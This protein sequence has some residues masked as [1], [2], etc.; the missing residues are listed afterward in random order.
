MHTLPAP[1]RQRPRLP[2]RRRYYLRRFI[3]ALLAIVVVTVALGSISL[4]GALRTPGNQS[5]QAKWADW[6]RAHHAGLIASAV[7]QYYY[8]HNAP[9]KGGRPAELNP[10]L[11]PAASSG[12]QP[13]TP[14][15]GLPRPVPIPLVVN[16]GLPGEGQWTP[17]GAVVRDVPA[18]YV[19]QFRADTV[20]TSQITSAVW[21]DPTLLRVALVPGAQ[22]PGGT[23]PQPPDVTDAGLST[24]VAA[25]NGGFRMADA[26]GGFYL[27]GRQAV[28]LRP[29]AASI[30]VYS[31]GRINIGSWGSEVTMTP[32][33]T[34]VL[35]NLV[36]IVDHGQPAPNATYSDTQIWGATLGAN[37]VV[38]RSGIGVTASGA[39]I[40][41]A[42]PALTARSLAESLQRAGAMRAMALDINPEWV[43]FNFYGHPNPA[44]PSQLDPAKLYPQ[45]Q[46]PATRY[47][48]PTQESRDF[49][50]VFLPGP[51]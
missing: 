40:Y 8:S 18:M 5:F 31:D 10:V 23:W 51:T 47:L 24:I 48:G 42:G 49:F 41:V 16:P 17:T 28:L 27:D 19:A 36:P 14:S 30:V 44:D 26:H 38:A 15:A 1:Y 20:Y 13:A 21:I 7:E 39:L 43:T 37:T 4:V 2:P 32:K 6:L 50:T 45:M 3:A 25:F 34:A 33:V 46:R 11:A 9:P 22:E 12:R 35:Q 29:G